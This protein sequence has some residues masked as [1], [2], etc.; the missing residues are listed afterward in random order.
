MGVP[1]FR[2]T[3]AGASHVPLTQKNFIDQLLS[4]LAAM[5]IILS[6]YSGYSFRYGATF[7]LQWG[8]PSDIIKIQGDWSSN[9]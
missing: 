2:Y 6:D 5:G 4:C 9:S 3:L 1:V 7:A 8:L